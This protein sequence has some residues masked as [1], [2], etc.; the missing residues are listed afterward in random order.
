MSWELM[1]SGLR[2]P[3]GPVACADGSVFV[4][5][6]AAGRVTRCLPDG[7]TQ[8]VAETGGGPNG[9]AFGPDGMLYCCNNGGFDYVEAGGLLIPHCIA[10]DYS[11]GRI[12][13]IDLRASWA[14]RGAH[15]GHTAK[16]RRRGAGAQG[17]PHQGADNDQERPSPSPELEAHARARSAIGTCGGRREPVAGASFVVGRKA[18]GRY[19]CKDAR[20]RPG[21]RGK[22]EETKLETSRG[23]FVL[24]AR[25][26]WRRAGTARGR[27]GA[28]D[29]AAPLSWGAARRGSSHAARCRRRARGRARRT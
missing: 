14:R 7:T 15:L 19:P 24:V 17:G 6:I 12:E 10:S 29:R 13:R 3:E 21:F 22:Q 23:A 20:G 28:R 27:A 16:W 5:E 2:F 4:T 8:V 11:G 26:R 1:T 9:L 25:A 18:H